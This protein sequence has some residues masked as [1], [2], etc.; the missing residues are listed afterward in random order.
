MQGV[1]EYSTDLFDRTTID[2]LLGHFQVLLAG[3]V[4]DADTRLSDLPLLTPDEVSQLHQ[5]HQPQVKPLTSICLHELFEAQVAKSPEA[6][7]ITFKQQPL[8]YAELNQRANQLAHYLQTEGVGP[9]TLVG[10]CVER[11]LEM[12]IR[13]KGID[14]AGRD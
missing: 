11:S 13:L 7:A 14:K 3:I 4:T 8:T 5:W 9:E 6:I 10:L 2:R 1:I 12:I